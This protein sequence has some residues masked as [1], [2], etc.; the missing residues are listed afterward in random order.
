MRRIPNYDPRLSQ[1]IRRN[2]DCVEI[3]SDRSCYVC[4]R[5]TQGHITV[6][7]DQSGTLK[8]VPLC[9]C[10]QANWHRL[11]DEEEREWL[12]P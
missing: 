7:H 6:E 2:E 5:R 4:G 11:R 10:C 12:A 3:V 9:R 8:L 1:L